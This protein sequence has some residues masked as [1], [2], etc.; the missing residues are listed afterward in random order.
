MSQLEVTLVASTK[1]ELAETCCA[2]FA[3]E[4]ATGYTAHPYVDLVKP[5]DELHEAGGRQCYESWGRPNPATATNKGYLGHILE[6]GHFSILE[7]GYATFFIRGTSRSLLLELERHR[8]L[9]YSVLSQRYVDSSEAEVVPP[10]L[11]D[12]ILRG[13]LYDHRDESISRYNEAV[14]VLMQQG[15]SRKEARG[16]A[17]A[18]LP[19]ATETKIFLSGNMRAFMEVIQKRNAE[20]ADIEIQL[21]AIQL[22]RELKRIAPNTFQTME[23]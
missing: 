9:S 20:G 14:D 6:V 17:R 23:V 8:H 3:L 12:N 16:A 11:F 13:Y 10:P 15:H 5:I 2:R 4:E 18:F 19:E 22:L 21:L 7:H 1:L